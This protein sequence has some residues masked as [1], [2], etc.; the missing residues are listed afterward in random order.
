MDKLKMKSKNWTNENIAKIAELFP[1]CVTEVEEPQINTNELRLEN[2]KNISENQ[3]SSVVKK[4][5]DWNLL[6]QELSD[7][8][9]EGSKE[10]YQLNWPGKKEALLTANQPIEKTLRPCRDESVNFDETE[11]LFI[12]G[13]N[14]DALKLLQE[15]YLE[16]IKMIYIDPPYNTGK[17]FIYSDKFAK[18][19]KEELE[20][21][22]QIDEEGNRLVANLES[23]GRFHSDW[24]SMM[25]PRLKLAR[26]LLKDDGVIF[27]SIN[28][29]ETH[30]L[31]KMCDEIFG[32]ENFISSL[33]TIMNLKGNQDAFGFSDTHEYTL[34]FAKDKT[35]CQLGFFKLDEDEID[36]WKE[37]DRGLYKKADTLRRTGQD[38]SRDRRPKGWFPVFITENNEIYV[39]EDNLPLSENDFVLYPKNDEGRELSWS[40]GKPKIV[41]ESYNLIVVNGKKGKNIYKKQRPALGGIPTKK[42]K[43]LFY[44]PDY[45]SSTATNE[46]K[47]ILNNK[48]FDSPK[49]VPLIK[50][51]CE[52]GC[53]NN[54]IIL[55]FFAGSATTAHAV[56]QLNSEELAEEAKK[57][58]ICENPCLSVVKEVKKG[59]R[60]FIMVQLPEDCDEKSEAFKAGYA[61]IAEISKE[62]IRRAGKKI[63]DNGKLKMNNV[64]TSQ[65]DN[66]PDLFDAKNNSQ[67]STINSQ[68]SIDTGFRVLKVDSTNMLDVYYSPEET[69]Q[70]DLGM[71]IDNIK[72]DRSE[73]DLLFQVLLDWGVDLTL[74]IRR[75]T[76]EP[77]INTDELRLENN[78]NICGNPCSSVVKNGVTVY[79]VDDDAL[80]A[81]FA[82]NGEVTEELCEA[83]ANTK[84]LRVVFRDA[85]FADSAAKTNA[86]ELFKLLSANTELKTI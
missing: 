20:D 76:I 71:R 32:T 67:L 75:E 18:S 27:I 68:L 72:N 81:C 9:V 8:I 38:A 22:E 16:K 5:I 64:K 54:D 24:L 10:R 33:P 77:Q 17:D 4:A 30:N 74:P 21:S 50:D 19:A 58:N 82:K 31:K 44:K 80:V 46:L 63:I 69:M 52:I 43:S 73:E 39:R 84:P 48:L 51:F 37:D 36:K 70:D 14:L 3:C 78:K 59:N 34:C 7:N 11:N 62:R 45:S 49:P 65:K 55:D 83:I 13:D 15:T 40:W 47:K 66:T 79:F 35:L 23:N 42:P 86:D 2:N 60:K 1:N 28:N 57:E 41:K 29:K 26:N 12:E 61:N 56:M 25:Y 6:K 53:F 85:G